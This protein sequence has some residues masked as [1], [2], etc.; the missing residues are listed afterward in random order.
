M[1][2]AQKH[3]INKLTIPGWITLTMIYDWADENGK[4]KIVDAAAA[5]A[6]IKPI[7]MKQLPVAP[8]QQEHS[9]LSPRNNRMNPLR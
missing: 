1:F 2:K 7:R 8:Y 6:G 5:K 4:R 3:N 9:Q